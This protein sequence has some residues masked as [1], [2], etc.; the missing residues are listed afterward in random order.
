MVKSEKIKRLLHQAEQCLIVG[1]NLT[2]KLYSR[3]VIKLDPKNA[4]SYYFLGEALCKQRKF[5]ESIQSLQKAR[6]LL[7][8]NARIIHLLGWAIFMSGDVDLGR[9]YIEQALKV[10][11]KDVQILSDLAVLEMGQGNMGEAKEHIL[12]AMDIDPNNPL[13]QEVF[14]KILSFNKV[15]K[16]LK[17]KAN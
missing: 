7:P 2:A 17:R 1:D 3:E 13:T 8:G 14:Q 4:E 15:R 6:K 12:K 9:V 11:S 16:R 5:A 10:L